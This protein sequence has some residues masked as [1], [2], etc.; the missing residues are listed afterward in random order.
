[1]A[2][3][4]VEGFTLTS[5]VIGLF[6]IAIGLGFTGTKFLIGMRPL[7]IVT[8]TGQPI[9]YDLVRRGAGDY[10]YN[11]ISI[12]GKV[13]GRQV[14]VTLPWGKQGELPALQKGRP[15]CEMNITTRQNG[16]NS[17]TVIIGE[18]LKNYSYC[19]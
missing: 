15:V 14:Q 16:F 4:R 18:E 8:V 17:K 11:D 19:R 7:N 9:T 12:I 1:M 2:N 13:N 3:S 10:P 6:M 5:L